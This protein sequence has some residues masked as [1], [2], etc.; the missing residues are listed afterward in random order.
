MKW[1]L[2]IKSTDSSTLTRYSHKFD[3]NIARYP[4]I[5]L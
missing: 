5:T 2:T 3:F 1:K 4:A